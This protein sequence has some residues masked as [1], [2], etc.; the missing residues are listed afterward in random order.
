MEH[1][2]IE[3]YTFNPEDYHDG[4]RKSDSM[5]FRDVVKEFEKI[6][7]SGIVANTL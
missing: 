3:T 7:I 4:R 1:E 6:S 2:I 5:T